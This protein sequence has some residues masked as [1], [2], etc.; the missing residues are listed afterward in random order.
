MNGEE[1]KPSKRVAVVRGQYHKFKLIPIIEHHARWFEAGPITIAV[2]ARALGS[3]REHLVGGPSIHVF[4]ADRKKEFLR[5]DL[6][7]N[8]LPYHYVLDD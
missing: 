8:V 4:S 1:R 3:S 6:F 2:E 7:G 5:F